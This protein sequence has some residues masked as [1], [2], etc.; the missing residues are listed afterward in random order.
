MPHNL[1]AVQ[2]IPVPLVKFQIAPRLKLVISSGSKKK[3]PRYVCL[4]EAKASHSQRMW[5]EVLSST[6]HLLHKGLLVTPI[7]WICLL[8]VLCP[9]R[10][11]IMTLDCVLWK[12]KIPVSALRL[13]PKISSRACLW[14][15]PR[16]RHLAQCWLCNQ[17]L[18]FLLILSLET[19]NYGSGPTNFWIE[20]SLA[21]LLAIS[22]PHTPLCSGTQYSPTICWVEITFYAFS[23]CCTNGNSVLVAW[24]A[25]WATWLSEQILTYFCGLPYNWIS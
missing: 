1:I 21:F 12:D 19:P 10:R 4:S 25:L 3:E 6:L 22:F 7:K 11:P 17:H 8:R 13:G 9:V 16:P 23:H 20:P 5:A 18:T 14:V 15:L 2:G 24:G